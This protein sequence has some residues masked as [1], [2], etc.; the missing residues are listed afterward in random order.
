MT[1]R[2]R[3]GF[4]RRIDCTEPFVRDERSTWPRRLRRAW[5]FFPN[6]HGRPLRGSASATTSG[7]K[8]LKL[9]AGARSHEASGPLDARPPRLG[10]GVRQSQD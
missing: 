8:W 4:A 6:S 9:P 3:S 7:H 5:E 10:R 1:S 2:Q